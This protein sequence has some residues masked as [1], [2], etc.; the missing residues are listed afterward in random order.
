MITLKSPV[1][2][3]K[4]ESHYGTIL[5]GLL[6]GIFWIFF[7]IWNRLIRERLPREITGE[8]EPYTISF[9]VILIFSLLYSY[10]VIYEINRLQKKYRGIDKKNAFLV[11]ISNYLIKF[12]QNHKTF[13]DIFNI[14]GYY[15]LKSPLYLWRFFYYNI[16]DKYHFS[17]ILKFA[18]YGTEA[19]YRY[20]NSRSKQIIAV[21]LLLY[22]PRLVVCSIFFYEVVINRYLHFFYTIAVIILIPLIFMGLRRMLF[23]ICVYESGFI[24]EYWIKCTVLEVDKE[25]FNSYHYSKKN[26]SISDAQF[27]DV[28]RNLYN[29]HETLNYMTKFYMITD[30]YNR[31]VYLVT[32]TLMMLSFITWTLIMAKVF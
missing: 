8:G 16:P 2:N 27:A 18:H 17:V 24:Q 19:C 26:P 14:L 10:S 32:D 6:M 22:I 11:K 25:G 13:S 23:D 1:F 28:G 29:F 30:K 20:F 21:I 15:V 3:E 31:K 9:W 5:L 12:L 4:F 7:I